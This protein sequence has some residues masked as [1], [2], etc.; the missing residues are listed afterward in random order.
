MTI[1]PIAPESVARHW[2]SGEPGTLL[3]RI[4]EALRQ[5]GVDPDA[6]GPDDLA[7]VD[8][9]HIRGREATVELAQLAGFTADQHVVDVGAGLGGP[10][11][12]LARRV[13]CRV[14]GVDLTEEYCRV[15]RELARRLGLADRVT[16]RRAD[17]LALPFPDATFDGA[18]TQHISM[19]I[20]DKRAF[21]AEM[22][23]V[24]KPGSH[25]AIYDPIGG[26]GRALDYPVPWAR[27]AEM[28]RLISETATRAALRGAGLEVLE[29]RD[30]TAVA[31]EWFAARARK[32]GAP[33][34]LHL[35]TGAEWPTM[36]GNMRENLATGRL[37]AV[38]I[39]ARRP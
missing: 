18:W 1:S 30:V 6:L 12:H 11:R 17:A 29:W 34:G 8:E 23:R 37:R 36:V 14:T 10:A 2:F 22:A 3:A 16:F 20:A 4:D 19:N 35:L 27:T 32:G 25:V 21:F 33:L 7:A 26:D 15:A 39:L 28:S 13:G 24:V 9:F 38:Q 31:V 5:G